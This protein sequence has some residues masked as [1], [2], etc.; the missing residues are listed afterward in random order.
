M[1]HYITN[2]D[3]SLVLFKNPLLNKLS[4]THPILP[5]VVFLPVIFYNLYFS[6]PLTGYFFTP[7]LFFC[8]LFFW[9]FVEYI[10]HRF[11]FHYEPKNSRIKKIHYLTHGVHHDYPSDST[12]LVMPLVISIPLAFLF[13]L[14]FSYILRQWT[15]ATYAGF[16]AGYLLYDMIHFATHHWNMTSVIGN[17]LRRYH[18]EHHFANPN[19][20]YGV[21]S[22]LWDYIFFTTKKNK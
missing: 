15:Q 14:V 11:V 5:I 16:I 20:S 22:P 1:N 4:H 7:I 21:S 19:T 2:K 18:L 10:L 8:G 3:E 9:S 6:I 12:R 13:Y 17:Y